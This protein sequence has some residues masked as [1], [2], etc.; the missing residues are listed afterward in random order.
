MTNYGGVRVQ[1]SRLDAAAMLHLSF[2]HF[3]LSVFII[4]CISSNDECHKSSLLITDMNIKLINSCSS[5]SDWLRNM[6][7][8]V[9][10]RFKARWLF[11]SLLFHPE[12]KNKREKGAPIQRST[13][14][15]MAVELTRNM[16]R[17][18]SKESN[19]GS[20]NSCNSEGKS[21]NRPFHCPCHR[22][23]LEKVCSAALCQVLPTCGRRVQRFRLDVSDQT[24]DLYEWTDRFLCFL[25]QFDL[26]W[27]E[28]GSQQPVQW[29]PG[30]T[31]TSSVSGQTNTG[32]SCYRYRILSFLV[33]SILF[34]PSTL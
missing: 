33:D 2:L 28:S 30:W 16:S 12:G 23:I 13:E 17:Q 14:T 1:M 7:V 21:V 26:L 25:W 29:L 11:L 18:P 19:N 10:L 9:R 22:L 3:R 6:N 8:F 27:S 15:G 4:I 31:G 32:Y 34:H 24:D 5:A 20:M